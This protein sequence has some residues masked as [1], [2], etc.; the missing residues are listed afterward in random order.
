MLSYALLH[1]DVE[2]FGASLARIGIGRGSRVATALP[3]GLETAVAMLGAMSFATCVP[4]DPSLDAAACRA[5]LSAL[6]STD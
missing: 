1:G 5:L 2:R 4:L 6:R 3:N